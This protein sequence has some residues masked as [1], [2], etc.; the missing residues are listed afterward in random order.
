L[1]PSESRLAYPYMSKDFVAVEER[2]F[3]SFFFSL[4]LFLVPLQLNPIRA[5]QNWSRA[6]RNGSFSEIP[7][8]SLAWRTPVC[9]FPPFI[10]VSLPVKSFY[11]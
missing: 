10:L 5:P 8:F 11:A 9:F 3:D 2:F 1:R 4:T 7:F 6:L